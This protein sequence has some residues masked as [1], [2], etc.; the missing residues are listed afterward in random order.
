MFA[1]FPGWYATLFSG[2][3][4]ALVLLL[5]ALIV[6]GVSF[7]FRGKRRHRPWRRTWTPLMTGAAC[8]SP[9]LIGIALGDLLHG[10]PIDSEQEFTGSLLDL[11]N[12]YA[13]FF[14]LT[15][16]VLCAFHGATF[17]GAED[18]RGRA[19]TGRTRWPG[20]RRLP[21]GAAGAGLRVL[22]PQHRR[23]GRGPQ[24]AAGRGGPGR[25]SPPAGCS[26][27]GAGRL[28]VR[29]DQRRDGHDRRCPSSPTS[30][31]G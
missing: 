11:L 28:G 6:R 13:L 3:Y 10:L 27:S 29:R 12:P 14:G 30:T 15:L 4:L 25:R 19:A 22:D 31:P 21:A 17:L 1:A 9:L 7:E 5:V 18:R 24:R 20:A 23:P 8:S 2:F 26:A 16:L